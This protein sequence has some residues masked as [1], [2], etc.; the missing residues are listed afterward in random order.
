MT[1]DER[2]KVALLGG[3]SLFKCSLHVAARHIVWSFG[4]QNISISSRKDDKYTEETDTANQISIMRIRNLRFSDAGD[5]SCK[6]YFQFLR[7]RESVFT[8]K[9]QGEV[10][11]LEVVL[12]VLSILFHHGF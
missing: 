5:Y 4:G 11:F 3:T 2:L 7:P 1:N 6:Q 10:S 8:L 9:V 12:F